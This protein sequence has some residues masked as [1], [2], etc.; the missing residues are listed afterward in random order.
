MGLCRIREGYF[1]GG[2]D[3]LGGKKPMARRKNARS[4]ISSDR[5]LLLFRRVCPRRQGTFQAWGEGERSSNLADSLWSFFVG[6]DNVGGEKTKVREKDGCMVIYPADFLRRI[7]AVSPDKENVSPS[8]DCF[9]RRICEGL[10]ASWPGR[11]ARS[12]SRNFRARPKYVR[13]PQKRNLKWP[14]HPS[15]AGRLIP[16]KSP[17]R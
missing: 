16:E 12:Q 17:P 2:V 3:Q 14:C 4:D 8:S 15:D 10:Y 6:V 13:I 11:A 9:P 1:F 7:L 5:P